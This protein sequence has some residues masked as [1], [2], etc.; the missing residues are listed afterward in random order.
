MALWTAD[1]AV[2]R[3]VTLLHHADFPLPDRATGIAILE[4]GKHPRIVASCA[5]NGVALWGTNK[6]EKHLERRDLGEGP[7]AA[8]IVTL[9]IG[10]AQH[11][12]YA[13]NRGEVAIATAD[14]LDRMSHWPDVDV[15]DPAW[16]G[17]PER[18]LL[19]PSEAR[20][21]EEL[22]RTVPVPVAATC[23]AA[24]AA[25]VLA[26]YRSGRVRSAR[27]LGPP[28]PQL[29]TEHPAAVHSV[30]AVDLDGQPY[31]VSGDDRGE[32]RVT[33]L[34]ATRTFTLAGHTRAVFATVPVLLDGHPHLYTGGLDRSLRL[35][36]LRSGRQA[37]VFWFPDTVCAIAVAPDG[38][39]YIGVGP[40][41]IHMAPHDQLQVRPIPT[42]N[43]GTSIR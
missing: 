35:W 11:V 9:T 37:D 39:L 43:Q 18:V 30:A 16:R 6:T 5:H 15:T 41:I 26:G 8:A 1:G 20:T 29:V 3:R 13:S 28:L 22:G 10:G 27:L 4:A 14:H 34:D 42:P 17:E 31:V 12:V 19:S 38:A 2:E 21:I 32:V 23:L 25:H 33:A 40:D 7:G 24:S 36:D